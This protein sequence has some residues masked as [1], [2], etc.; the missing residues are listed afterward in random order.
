MRRNKAPITCVIIL[1]HPS[2]LPNQPSKALE[3]LVIAQSI[4]VAPRTRT[5]II[6]PM[7]S[8]VANTKGLRIFGS[9]N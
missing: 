9:L 3:R 4:A 2:A 6:D 5:R 1:S 8:R 7:V